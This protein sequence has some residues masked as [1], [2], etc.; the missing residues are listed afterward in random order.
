MKLFVATFYFLFYKKTE[1]HKLI[2]TPFIVLLFSFVYWE[3]YSN[4]VSY[5]VLL[6]LVVLVLCEV[7]IC[8]FYGEGSNVALV[9][10]FV[11][12]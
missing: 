1:V 8:L 4:K 11:W 5:V 2:I 6:F 9:I 3:V 12:W 10:G 7:F